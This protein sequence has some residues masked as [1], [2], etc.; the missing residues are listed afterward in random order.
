MNILK[1]LLVIA[2]FGGGI[3][4]L[5]IR[6][7]ATMEAK[8]EQPLSFAI[9]VRAQTVAEQ[10]LSEHVDIGGTIQANN[11]VS[12]IAETQGR[13]IR[14]YASL[15][16]RVRKGSAL[17]KVDTVL[18][19]SSFMLAKSSHDK[20]KKDLER[21]EALRKE[22]NASES[23]LESAQLAFQNAKSQMIIAERQYADARIKSP[24]NGT[25]VERP[26]NIGSMVVPGTPIATVVDIS[27]L[28]LRAQL[29]E[30]DILKLRVGDNVGVVAD[31]YPLVKFNGKVGFISVR[32]NEAHSYPIE[33]VL[34]NNPQYPLKSGMSARIYREST[35][36]H[37]ALMIPR[38]A[39]IGSTKEPSVY[40]LNQVKGKI[41]AKLR[42]VQLGKENGTNIEVKGGLQR[43]EQ[44][45]I[46]GQ[47]N[48]RD[49]AEVIV[50]Q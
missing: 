6:N 7:K 42:S 29:P 4:F 46:A 31:I 27:T 15:G 38:L 37:T 12:V 33:V 48:A 3:A 25:V 45:I 26:V 36:S 16:D 49:G 2:L 40:V 50:Q 35:S 18:T 17:V 20:A 11:E 39:V 47:N 28:R 8:A 13:V 19:Y 22:N 41:Q 34:S 43:G 23:E 24:I 44:V 21:L 5:L 30:Q 32:G 1:I 14:V 10:V 9:S